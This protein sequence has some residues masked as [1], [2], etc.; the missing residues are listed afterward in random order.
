M[1]IKIAV[2]NHHRNV[3]EEMWKVR[4]EQT[5]TGGTNEYG[6]GL[7][8][9]RRVVSGCAVSDERRLSLSLSLSTDGREE[10]TRR[11]LEKKRESN[12]AEGESHSCYLEK[13]V[14]AFNP[15]IMVHQPTEA[16]CP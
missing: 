14:V 12:S 6:G 15:T 5:L 7:E 11:K 8:W 9:W 16:H 3:K 2:S 4:D 13:V 1:K 10:E